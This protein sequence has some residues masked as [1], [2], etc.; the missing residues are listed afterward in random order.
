VDGPAGV[1][2]T[3]GEI[4]EVATQY[5]REMFK[6]EERPSI[7]IGNDFFSEGDKVS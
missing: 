4:I 5:Y 6:A 2:S 1:V 7:N 3:T